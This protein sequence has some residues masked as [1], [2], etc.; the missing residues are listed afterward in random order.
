MPKLFDSHEQFQ[1]WFSKDIEAHSIGAQKH[2]NQTQLSRLHT[3][4][5]PFMLRR[6]KKDVEHELGPK[7]E[8][9]LF[10][11][12][13]NR[14]K[15]LYNGIKTKVGDIKDLVRM[16]DSKKKMENLMNLVMQLRKVCNHPE[17]FERKIG[18]IPFTFSIIYIYIYIYRG[19]D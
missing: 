17:L 19:L 18:K 10:V 12:M 9:S 15:V 8:I 11:E 2:L 4:L 1:E 7:D 5:K 6:V 16:V 13:T 3:V 14:Q